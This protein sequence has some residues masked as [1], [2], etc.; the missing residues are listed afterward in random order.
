MKWLY[1]IGLLH[2]ERGNRKKTRRKTLPF[3][4]AAP[5][6]RDIYTIIIEL[7]YSHKREGFK[8]L[9]ENLKSIPNV[10]YDCGKK[11]LIITLFKKKYYETFKESLSD[12]ADDT[13]MQIREILGN[14][15]N[16]RLQGQV[17]GLL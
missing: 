5:R 3:L 15:S 16:K 8:V 6:N 4:C 7:A 17:T 14:V 9:L 1:D 12:A 10:G 11:E 13:K 2:T